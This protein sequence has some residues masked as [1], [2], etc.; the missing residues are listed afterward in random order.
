MSSFICLD[1]EGAPINDRLVGRL[2]NIQGLRIKLVEG[3]RSVLDGWIGG[4][5]KNKPGSKGQ[6]GR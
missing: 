6:T 5:G 2:N 3:Y 1:A 4:Q